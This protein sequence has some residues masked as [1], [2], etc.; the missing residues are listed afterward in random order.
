MQNRTNLGISLGQALAGAFGGDP[1]SRQ[2]GQLDAMR[3]NALQ[4]QIEENQ[5]DA[6]LKQQTFDAKSDDALIKSLVGGLQNGK[7][8]DNPFD[9]FKAYASGTYKPREQQ[10][11]GMA[12]GSYMPAPEYVSKFPELQQKFSALKQMMAL[13]DKNLEHLSGSIRGDQRNTITKALT[14][15]NAAQQSLVIAALDGKDPTQ[16]AESDIIQKIANGGGNYEQLLSAVLAGKGKGKFDSFNGGAMNVATGKQDLNAIGNSMVDEN[17]ASALQSRAGA[18]ENNAQAGLANTRAT[19]IKE[20]KG[21]GSN[22]QQ[23]DFAQ[24]RDDI[25]SDY[26]ATYPISSINGKRPKDAPSYESFTKS[27]LKQYNVDENEFFRVNKGAGSDK[28]ATK[29]TSKPSP[30]YQEYLDAFNKAAGNP[31]LQKKITERARKLGAVK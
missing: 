13:E 2:R 25:R 1:I 23:K 11:P 27:W 12:P 21:D 9:D 31:A 5:A 26:N 24:I 15:E 4:S 16:I 22:A 20:G 3:S 17:L 7:N 28:P 18:N 19:N 10:G 14:P 8:G 30:A 6:A 29:Q